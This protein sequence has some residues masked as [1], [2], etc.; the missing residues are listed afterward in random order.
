MV[1]AGLMVLVLVAAQIYTDPATAFFPKLRV[2]ESISFAL[3][4][5]FEGGNVL[6]ITLAP[7]LIA[8]LTYKTSGHIKNILIWLLVS[9]EVSTIFCSNSVTV[10]ITIFLVVLLFVLITLLRAGRKIIAGL[11]VLSLSLLA[12][13]LLYTSSLPSFLTQNTTLSGRTAIWWSTLRLA[14]DNFWTGIGWQTKLFKNNANWDV[15]TSQGEIYFRHAHNDLLHWFLVT[16]IFGIIFL[17]ASL[18]AVLILSIGSLT[19]KVDERSA[20]WFLLTT[21]YLLVTG[22]TEVVT[23]YPYQWF[24]LCLVVGGAYKVKSGNNLSGTL[25]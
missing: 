4:G 3:R 11:V 10:S 9:L 16:G 15:L 13:W 25:L 5:P 22:L 20:L 1:V 2:D 8:A 24:V 21:I 18:A 19:K 14:L 23:V 7:C 17:V 6:A 12:S